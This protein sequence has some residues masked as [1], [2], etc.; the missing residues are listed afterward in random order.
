MDDLLIAI[1]KTVLSLFENARKG[2]ATSLAL[3]MNILP[4]DLRFE[5]AGKL[6]DELDDQKFGG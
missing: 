4:D 5:I 3:L 2:D 6:Q 1:I